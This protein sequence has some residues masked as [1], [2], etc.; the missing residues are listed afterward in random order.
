MV[1]ERERERV[2]N[3]MLVFGECL[4]FLV[5]FKGYYM[6]DT[7]SNYLRHIFQRLNVSDY[8]IVERNNLMQRYPSDF[9][10]VRVSDRFSLEKIH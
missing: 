2:F 3:L 8:R 5:H 9:D 1:G 4:E 10:I 7:R 6:A